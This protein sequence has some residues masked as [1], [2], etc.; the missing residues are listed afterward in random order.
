MYQNASMHM[1]ETERVYTY[2]VC[3]RSL[4]CND[5]PNDLLHTSQVYVYIHLTKEK[6]LLL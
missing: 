6:K 3:N 5:I 1:L 4:S 2:G